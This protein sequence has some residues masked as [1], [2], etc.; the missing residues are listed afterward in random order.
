MEA[1][2]DEFM[3]IPGVTGVA[4]GLTRKKVPC[5][6]VLVVRATNEVRKRVPKEVEGHPVEMIET[7]EI[8]DMSDERD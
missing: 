4:I 5:I 3:S 2:T 7:G 8:R 1:H 6:L